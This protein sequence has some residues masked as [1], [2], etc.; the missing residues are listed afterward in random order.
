MSLKAILE[1]RIAKMKCPLPADQAFVKSAEIVEAISSLSEITIEFLSPDKNLELAKVVGKSMTIS[2]ETK[3]E[4]FRDFVGVCVEAE[5]L[6]LYHGYGLYTAQ[7][8]PWLWFLTLA[9]DNRIFQDLNVEDIIKKVFSDHGFSDFQVKKSATYDPRPYTVQYRETDFD[10]ISRLMEEE[11]LYYFSTYENGKEKLILGDGTG[12]HAPVPDLEGGKIEFHYRETDYRRRK[13]HIFEWQGSESV[14]P[15]K[16]SLS[17][18]NF[19]KPKASQLVTVMIPKGTHAHKGYE[20]YRTPGHHRETPLGNKF[21]RVEMEQYAVKH[22]TRHA[23]G[24]L[25]TLAV[26]TTFALDG[27]PRASENAE[28]LIT[29]ATHYLQIETDV[30]DDDTA[31]ALLPGRLA[32]DKNNKDVY[33]CVFEVVPKS[34]PFRA[35]R[36]TPW[37]EVPGLVLAKVVGP[38]GEEIFTD[39]YGRIKVKFP[40]DRVGKDDDKATCFVRTVTPWAGKSWGFVAVP[41]IGQEVAI[42]FEDGNPDRP[43]C[44]GMLYNSD[45]MPPYALAANMT[46]SG[47]KTNSS[48]G[49]GGFNELMMEDK[50]GEELVRFQAEKDYTQIVKNNATITIGIEKK[51]KGDLT[52]TI[53]RHK[54]ETLET[55]DHT[56]TVKDGNETRKIKKNKVEE[57]EGTSK[58]TVTKDVKRTFKANETNEVTGDVKTTINKTQT[59]E[60]LSDIIHKSKTGAITIEAMT[61]ITLKVGENTITIDKVGVTIDGGMVTITGKTVT[62]VKGNISLI[63]KG[64]MTMIN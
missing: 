1:N 46:Q 64:G 32:L 18:Y 40:W 36:K 45:N 20:R 38:A 29:R 27:H 53:Y 22:E 28:Y 31:G 43:I 54:T 57:V 63:L 4:T 35:E 58:L 61:S 55:G 47:V 6:G 44:T 30:E 52:Q 9:S 10:F 33:R 26:G 14:R 19:E 34:M 17:D 12:A 59:T 15:G 3:S 13:D 48:K 49:G 5:Y 16:V 7:V 37:P 25:R 41:R 56:F 60:V 11:G 21:A 51:D 39:K 50:K 8:R 62:E 23:V 24:N 2:I 42:Q